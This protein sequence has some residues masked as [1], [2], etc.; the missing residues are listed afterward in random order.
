M[1]RCPFLA[2]LWLFASMAA[3]VPVAPEARPDPATVGRLLLAHW[4]FDEDGGTVAAD[5]GGNGRS[6]Q[7]ELG[8]GAAGR[9]VPGVF[10]AA[11]RL[12]GRHR[13]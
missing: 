11:L 1:Q 2:V 12:S 7:I 6:I 5:I 3:S 4:P 9:R 13:L 8:A 10:G